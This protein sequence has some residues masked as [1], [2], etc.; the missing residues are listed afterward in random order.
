[1]IVRDGVT[2]YQFNRYG[3]PVHIRDAEGADTYY[4]YTEDNQISKITDPLG[5]QE[6]FYYDKKGQLATY[7]DKE[8]HATYWF[9]ND[10]GQVTKIT[11]ALGQSWQRRY[12]DMGQVEQQT[13]PFRPIDLLSL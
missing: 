2:M 9:R 11:N 8:H 13:D 4:E 1:M 6:S 5:Q 12:N 10:L 3:L 7:V